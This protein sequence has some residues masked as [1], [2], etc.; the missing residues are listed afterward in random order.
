MT[1]PRLAIFV[2]LVCVAFSHPASRQRAI[3]SESE[4]EAQ[5]A[6]GAL[7]WR[8]MTLR[9]PDGLI[10]PDGLARARAQ[11]RRMS[12]ESPQ[13]QSAQTAGSSAQLSRAG[14]RWLGPG[15]IGGRVR[16]IVIHPINTDT[17]FAGS[18]AGGIWRSDDAGESWRP[19]DDFMA[20]L[21]VSSLVINPR[22]PNVMYAGTGEIYSNYDALHGGGIFK[23][24]DVGVTWALLPATAPASNS[25]FFA[26]VS[27]LAMSPDGSVLMAAA[28]G[29]IFRTADGGAT[30]T[31]STFGGMDDVDIDPSNGSKAIAVAFSGAGYYTRDGGVTWQ[32]STGV[33]TTSFP[34]RLE[35]T[36]ARSVPDL[37]YMATMD[38]ALYVSTNGGVSYA[39]RFSALGFAQGW[40]NLTLWVNPRDANHL[41][42]GAEELYESVD[43]GSSWRQISTTSIHVDH[44]VIVEHP[45]FDNATNRTVYF[46]N[47][48]GVYRADVTA[49][50]TYAWQRRIGNLGI[51]QF[52]GAAGN[53]TQYGTE[54]GL[55][56]ISARGEKWGRGAHLNN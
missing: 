53:P 41:I 32:A 47:D 23:S 55:K 6:R 13:L 28:G 52:Y 34:G 29:L 12:V 51:T 27:R 11:M 14:W 48:G 44:H 36:Y 30:F 39:R 5:D 38:G 21:A 24:T 26:G 17:L 31:R 9:G 37:V 20:N 1:G 43:G 56:S 25:A 18:V 3:E 50:G 42:W 8:A 54:S 15:D 16:S 10:A 2:A 49:G 22:D 19:V 45:R 46:G 7:E 33:P 40:Y 35:I 4:S